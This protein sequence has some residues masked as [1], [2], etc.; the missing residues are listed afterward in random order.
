MPPAAAAA[1]I[2]PISPGQRR[3]V[4]TTISSSISNIN[5]SISMSRRKQANPNR[6][7]AA[8]EMGV[9]MAPRG[10]AAAG[11]QAGS[12]LGC[13]GDANDADGCYD[14][15]LSSVSAMMSA[16]MGAA[17]LPRPGAHAHLVGHHNNHLDID[18]DAGER[19]VGGGPIAG[20]AAALARRAATIDGA[21]SPRSLS[22]APGRAH[23]QNG[24]GSGARRPVVGTA[25]APVVAATDTSPG[26]PGDGGTGCHVCR[27][28]R[29]A[30]SSASS[31]DRHMLVHSGERP[32]RCPV[33]RQA[34]TTNGNMHR[35]MKIHEK[36]PGLPDPWPQMAPPQ[37]HPLGCPPVQELSAP[38]IALLGPPVTAK[39]PLSPA[40][41]EDEPWSS[42]RVAHEQVEG[43]ERPGSVGSACGPGAT[44]G[45]RECHEAP[46]GPQEA[47][48]RCPLCLKDSAVEEQLGTIPRCEHC[49]PS[50]T[51]TSST[52][53]STT[54]T[55]ISA[56]ST[57]D[58]TEPHRVPHGAGS[59]GLSGGATT[60]SNDDDDGDS[61]LPK[62]RAAPMSPSP[63]PPTAATTASPPLDPAHIQSNPS[64]IPSGFQQLGFV[65]FCCQKFPLIAKAWCEENA[66]R[67]ASA[68]HRF[69]CTACDRAFPMAAALQLHHRT[70]HNLHRSTSVQPH[71]ERRLH[72]HRDPAAHPPAPLR[73]DGAVLGTVPS[74][75]ADAMVAFM[76]YLG[77]RRATEVATPRP[78]GTAASGADR[79]RVEASR[80][81]RSPPV[82]SVTAVAAAPFPPPRAFVARR[83]APG[84][85][86]ARSPLPVLAGAPSGPSCELADI[87]QILLM[88]ATASPGTTGVLLPLPPLSKAPPLAPSSSFAATVATKLMPA[89][90]PKPRA[91]PSVTAAAPPVV[92]GTPSL[93]LLPPS[94]TQAA[95]ALACRAPPLAPCRAPP[96]ATATGEAEGSLGVEGAVARGGGTVVPD[97]A[98]RPARSVVAA[99]TVPG[100]GDAV[101]PIDLSVPKSNGAPTKHGAG[102]AAPALPPAPPAAPAA[103]RPHA[104]E[105]PFRCSAAFRAK[106]N[107][108]KHSGPS[109]PAAPPSPTGATG[110]RLLPPPSGPCPSG[111]TGPDGT[112]DLS[113]P[114]PSSPRDAAV[115]SPPPLGTLRQEEAAETDP[116]PRRSP[117]SLSA[118]AGGWPPGPGE[119]PHVRRRPGSLL[120]RSIL[121]AS[122]TGES[123]EKLFLTGGGLARAV[124]SKEPPPLASIAQIISSVSAAPVLLRPG[125]AAGAGEEKEGGDPGRANGATRRESGPPSFESERR[126][127]TAADSA[128][129]VRKRGRPSNAARAAL[130]NGTG[131]RPAAKRRRRS[132]EPGARSGRQSGGGVIG[133]GV[134]GG[135]KGVGSEAVDLDSSGEFASIE[136]MLDSM[137]SSRFMVLLEAA[138]AGIIP[139]AP[140]RPRVP[141]AGTGGSGGSGGEGESDGGHRTPERPPAGGDGADGGDGGL[142]EEDEDGAE[143]GEFER[144]GGLKRNTYSNS[145]HRLK[146]PHCPRL[147]PWISSLQRHMLTH[148]GEGRVA[149]HAPHA[150][151]AASH[152]SRTPRVAQGE[153]AGAATAPRVS[154]IASR[155][156]RPCLPGQKPYP[157]PHCSAFFSTKSNCERHLTRKHM[158]KGGTPATPWQLGCDG[159]IG[160]QAS[161]PDSP[162]CI[163]MESVEEKAM[164]PGLAVKLEIVEDDEGDDGRGSTGP[165]TKTSPPPSPR[166]SPRPSPL[167]SSPAPSPLPG[168][169]PPP[170]PPSSP[171]PPSLPPP[172]LLPTVPS[173][174]TPSQPSPSQPSPLPPPSSSISSVTHADAGTSISPQKIKT[175]FPALANG[176][177]T[178][179]NGNCDDA[180]NMD[181]DDD[182]DEEEEQGEGSEGW[183]DPDDDTS[184]NKSLDLDFAAKLIDFK[185]GP[186]GTGVGGLAI[187]TEVTAAA[188]G[189]PVRPLAAGSVPAALLVCESCGKTFRHRAVLAR[190][191]RVHTAERPF[192]CPQCERTFTTKFNLQRHAQRHAAAA[193]PAAAAARQTL[194][195]LLP[196]G[197]LPDAV[198]P[199]TVRG[200]GGIA[201]TA[202]DKRGKRG[203][204][205]ARRG[206]GSSR[207]AR[208]ESREHGSRGSEHGDGA[209]RAGEDVGEDGTAAGDVERGDGAPEGGEAGGGK[210]REKRKK[211]CEVCNKRFWSLQDLTRHMRSHTGERPYKCDTCERTFT[212]KHSLVRHRRIHDKGGRAEAWR[213]PGPR[214]LLPAP[215]TPPPAAQL[216]GTASPPP[217]DGAPSPPRETRDPGE[218]IQ[219]SFFQSV[220][221]TVPFPTLTLGCWGV[222]AGA[223]G[224]GRTADAGA[225]GASGGLAAARDRARRSDIIK[226]LLGLP[227]GTV[228]EQMLE[229][230][231]SAAQLLGV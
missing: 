7:T 125:A 231:D 200:G 87:Q 84:A 221:A 71:R 39:R 18:R 116:A 90:K 128:P 68:S 119:G 146:C 28:C 212:L 124:A 229:S 12:A 204:G 85:G 104:D 132:Y 51:S 17:Q 72:R 50:S 29:R 64:S 93:L 156:S 40:E 120:L 153:R 106:V 121:A 61:G 207:D 49:V 210:E 187:P 193:A 102:T 57:S 35:H 143:G 88:A 176:F 215:T 114:L 52:S 147:F 19:G 77:L 2:F 41:T 111:G 98:V 76:G 79:P 70:H 101:E 154:L 1:A 218:V 89:L 34:F 27:V 4:V 44:E 138:G 223:L 202:R 185:L 201:V 140:P 164:E 97:F 33:C 184:S 80:E 190:H 38:P 31:L 217:N 59:P 230:A 115:P 60:P 130:A 155:V 25:G 134:I 178:A 117:A 74:D 205:G 169:A 174:P 141:S 55:N 73:P 105:R 172:P 214:C 78:A 92:A 224:A 129:A 158:G 175:E 11:L 137:D 157:C 45:P 3:G 91:P 123:P 168:L 95:S 142:E 133:D 23:R 167:P 20:A 188:L 36:E 43:G 100:A 47:L 135:G 94:P 122:G 160:G 81:G 96:V 62:L 9:V 219:G 192:R 136:R 54:S 191:R 82:P 173:Q 16:V 110:A 6:V 67:S 194:A 151:L 75:P 225:A 228:L 159:A 10:F 13:Y 108:D 46:G 109:G 112:A 63:P 139:P 152:A 182:D 37:K 127:R 165:A 206:G 83:P 227:D 131:P 8:M 58:P 53:S 15:D 222:A 32:Y 198:V 118:G 126:R 145:V 208:C 171:S 42:K 14:D 183:D 30:L 170:T 86:P 211:V 203:G 180:N 65:D 220:G 213:P 26:A 22:P 66:R 216:P 24:G 21:L 196:S 99:D 149:P 103:P 189:G 162:R 177:A 150:A 69:V 209:A 186:G 107:L 195:K 148:T 48:W 181:D 5:S 199:A 56:T 197:P 161:P 144:Q 163:C 166:S 179:T 113:P 226:S